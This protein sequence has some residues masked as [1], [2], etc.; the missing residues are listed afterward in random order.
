[1]TQMLHVS[2]HI[3]LVVVIKGI[4]VLRVDALVHLVLLIVVLPVLACSTLD[5]KVRS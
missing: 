5:P 3:R 1:M 4:I 2:Q